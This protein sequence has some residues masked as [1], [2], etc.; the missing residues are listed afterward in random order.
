MEFGGVTGGTG[1]GLYLREPGSLQ[2]QVAAAGE[3]CVQAEVT[4]FAR[5]LNE[6]RM[7]FALCFLQTSVVPFPCLHLCRWL[8][9]FIIAV[10]IPSTRSF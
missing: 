8:Q 6:P 2:P 10:L 4:N 1:R 9:N 3:W 7:S 5:V